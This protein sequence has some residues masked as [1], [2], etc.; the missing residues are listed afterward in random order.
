MNYRK[1]IEKLDNC[2]QNEAHKYLDRSLY[3]VG[4]FLPS[5]SSKTHLDLELSLLTAFYLV[6]LKEMSATR[7]LG[8]LTLFLQKNV[9]LIN[10]SKL[11]KMWDHLGRERAPLMRLA[12]HLLGTT[13]SGNFSPFYLDQRM[14][15][16]VDKK[17][18]KEGTF[19]EVPLSLGLMIPAGSVRL[20]E[21]DLVPEL[22]LFK[23]NKQLR[24][25]LFMG[26]TFR[27]DVSFQLKRNPA[28]TPSDLEKRF[29]MTHEPAFRLLTDLK[30]AR[31][32]TSSNSFAMS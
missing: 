10:R 22:V 7:F 25:R 13:V 27:A 26:G 28:T 15:A 31:S 29:A 18:A 17:L 11:Q 5:Y 21:S 2:T 19:M 9:S 14:K 8:P 32:L 30:R 4:V 3:Q 23:R 6:G 1:F 24:E 20:R 16:L 12:M